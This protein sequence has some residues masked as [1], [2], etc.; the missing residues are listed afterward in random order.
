[1]PISQMSQKALTKNNEE[2]DENRAIDRL[3]TANK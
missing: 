1:M 3:L 2:L